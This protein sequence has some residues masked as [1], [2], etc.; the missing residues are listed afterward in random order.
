[1]EKLRKLILEWLFGTDDIPRYIKVLDTSIK[2][3]EEWSKSI[4]SHRE[5]IKSAKEDLDIT[6]KLIIICKNHGIDIDK[7]IDEVNLLEE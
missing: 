4:E 3:Y 5:T 1:M 7:E 6:R 2:Y